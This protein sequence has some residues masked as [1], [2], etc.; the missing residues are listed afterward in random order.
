MDTNNDILKRILNE[1]EFQDFLSNTYVQ[2][3][4]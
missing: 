4:Y 2:K 3:V 1:S